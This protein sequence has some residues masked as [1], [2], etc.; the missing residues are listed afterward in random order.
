MPVGLPA[1][2]RRGATLE[3]WFVHTPVCAASRAQILT[4]RYFH[5]LAD[6]P[7]A[8]DPWDRAGNT[9]GPCFAG[10]PSR[11]CGPPSSAPGSNMHLNFSLLSPGPTFAQHLAQ[12]AGYNVGV[13]GKYLNRNP[14]SP[15]GQPVIPAGVSHWFVAPGDEANKSTARDPSGEYFP[16]FYYDSG[17]P[18]GV[19]NNTEAQYETALLGN[20]SINWLREAATDPRGRPFFLYLAPHSP[21]GMALPAPWYASLPINATAP[22][23]PSWNVSAQD[24]HWLIAKQPPISTREAAALDRHFQDRWRCLRA[25]DDLLA[26]LETELSGMGLWNS[27]YVFFSADHGYHFG[28]LRLGGGKWNVYD[29]DIRVPMRVIGP[30]IQANTKLGMVGSHVDL[31]PTWLELAGLDVPADMDG[32]SLL[33]GLLDHGPSPLD[34]LGSALARAP[35]APAPAPRGSGGALPVGGAYIE[36]HGLGPTGATSPPFFRQ[37]DAF[38]NTYRALRVIDRRAGGLGNVLYA[39]FGT[40]D[41]TTIHTREFFDIDDDAW[42]THNRYAALP[43]AEKVEWATRLS[44]MFRCSG[45]ACRTNSSSGSVSF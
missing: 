6:V 38:N 24:H 42:Q 21:H 22:R 17:E 25:T 18:S 32:H 23:S 7:A 36:Y 8:G 33:G 4:G 30:G 12:R 10:R 45:A 14:L 15:S 34:N 27:T 44:N 11:G 9:R 16:S 19:W 1:L 2:S 39:E 40:Y 41:F 3:N 43:A 20:R 37:Q 35:A 31:A 26:A 28:E 29:T 13:F 5:N